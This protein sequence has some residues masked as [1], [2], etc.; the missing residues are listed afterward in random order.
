[1][2]AVLFSSQRS[3]RSKGT[4]VQSDNTTKEKL[5]KV[6]KHERSSNH[7]SR[8]KTYLLHPDVLTFEGVD[9]ELG[10]ILFA[11]WN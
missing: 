3:V 8:P 1:M 5:K 4:D 10:H 2:H 6:Y 11:I 7:T 9:F